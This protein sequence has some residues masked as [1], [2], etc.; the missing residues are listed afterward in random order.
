MK[1]LLKEKNDKNR[2]KMIKEASADEIFALMDAAHNILK[3]NF[4]LS[5]KQRR[6]LAVY[7]KALRKLAKKKTV[8]EGRKIIQ[9]GRGPMLAALLVPVLTEVASRL[10]SRLNS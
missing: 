10:I 2:L 5:T 3:F 9:K 1:S 6:K 4:P 7:A 8:D